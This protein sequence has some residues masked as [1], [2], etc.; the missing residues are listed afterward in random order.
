ME[1]SIALSRTT[2]TLTILI[3]LAVLIVPAIFFFI[4]YDDFKREYDELTNPTDIDEMKPTKEDFDKLLGVIITVIVLIPILYLYIYVVQKKIDTTIYMVV[5]SALVISIIVMFVLIVVFGF[6]FSDKLS[7][8]I[9]DTAGTEAQEE[10]VS[11]GTETLIL[12]GIIA[13]SSLLLSLF[14][15]VLYFM[16]AKNPYLESRSKRRLIRKTL[17]K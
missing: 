1:L 11:K 3:L 16:L 14:A 6:N 9:R 15:V 8:I 2:F 4:R 7:E 13:A 10:V 5:F 12:I 17:F